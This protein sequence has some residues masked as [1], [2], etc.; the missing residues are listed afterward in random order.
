MPGPNI[1]DK[2]IANALDRKLDAVNKKLAVMSRLLRE[3]NVKMDYMLQL[4]TSRS[5]GQE[6]E[7]LTAE[8]FIPPTCTTDTQMYSNEGATPVTSMPYQ[9]AADSTN[10]SFPAAPNCPPDLATTNNDDFRDIPQ[11]HR[12]TVDQ[13]QRLR[14][15]SKS[16][17][18]F[19]TRLLTRVFPE[20][21][22]EDQ[23]RRK[24][25]Y[26]GFRGQKQELDR[27]R[28]T[29][30][31]RYV[32]FMHPE[33]RDQKAYQEKIVSAVNEYLRRPNI[34]GADAMF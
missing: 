28:K 30:F 32:L 29:Y 8:P 6:E 4:L 25:N 33:L 21:F 7:L 5:T 1:V 23:L 15:H 16:L 12:L 22:G 20:L 24:Y 31:Q 13:L 26:Y 18:T 9:Y 11:P 2:R 19:A 3:N 17:S 14:H 10:I 27:Q 34:A